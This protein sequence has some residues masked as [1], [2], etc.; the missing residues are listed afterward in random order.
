M[1]EQD[2]LAAARW[3]IPA[4]GNDFGSVAR[5]GEAER[6]FRARTEPLIHADFEAIWPGTDEPSSGMEATMTALHRVGQA[7]DALI[8]IPELYVPL[9]DQ[10]VLVLLHRDGRTFNGFEF[11]EPGG[12]I[13]D[14]EDGLLRRMTLFAHRPP[15]L[16]QAGL[17]AE[18]AESRGLP[19]EP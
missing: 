7:F 9:D 19:P 1:S 10:R 12:V 6:A 17:T 3:L 13:Y 18:E 16:E 8:A 4:E 5:G 14:F 2:L 15:A 11:S